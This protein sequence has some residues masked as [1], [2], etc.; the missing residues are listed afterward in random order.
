MAKSIA[1]GGWSEIAS[2]QDDKLFIDITDGYCEHSIKIFYASVKQGIVITEQQKELE[3][4]EECKFGNDGQSFTCR[5][6]KNNPLS[7]ATYKPVQKGET[8]CD[9]ALGG[10]IVPVYV[11]HGVK[12]CKSVPKELRPKTDGCE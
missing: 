4:D 11:Y 3:F 7:G 12:G 8:T 1:Y 5:V 9:E 2:Y 10:G 6:N